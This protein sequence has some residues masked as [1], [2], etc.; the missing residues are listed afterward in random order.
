MDGVTEML[1]VVFIF[2]WPG[3]LIGMFLVRS[4]FN[5]RFKRKERLEARRMFERLMHRKLDAVETALA[6]GWTREELYQ[7]DSKLERLIGADQ[8]KGLLDRLPT[9]SEIRD[10]PEDQLRAEISQIRK[11][12]Q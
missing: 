5:E 3:I 10:I 1:A 11:A 4:H 7:L 9:A 12:R 8:M 2:G 6:L